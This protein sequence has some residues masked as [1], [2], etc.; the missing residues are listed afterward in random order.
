M[1]PVDVDQR[2]TGTDG[3][4]LLALPEGVL[5][6][7]LRA[8]WW[9]T[10]QPRLGLHRSAGVRRCD[11]LLVSGSLRLGP[12]RGHGEPVSPCLYVSG[13]CICRDHLVDL[14]VEVDV[15]LTRSAGTLRN[16]AGAVRRHIRTRAAGDWTRSRRLA[17]GAQARSDRIR[18]GAR[19]RQLP[20]DVHRAILEYLVDEAGSVAPL[21]D[22]DQLLTRLAVRAAAEFGGTAA[23]HRDR[24]LAMLPLIEAVC[25]TGPTSDS[26]DGEQ[27]TWWERYIDR[28]LGRRARRDVEIDAL[29]GEAWQLA[30]TAAEAAFYDDGTDDAQAT[31]SPVIAEL[32]R[33]RSPDL[34]LGVR[35]AVLEMAGLGLLPEPVAR[36]FV[37]DQR[38][39]GIAVDLLRAERRRAGGAQRGHLGATGAAGIQVHA[40]TD[41]L[42]A[43]VVNRCSVRGAPLLPIPRCAAADCLSGTSDVDRPRLR[44]LLGYGSSR[45]GDGPDAEGAP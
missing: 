42:R 11:L 22:G 27:L 5:D 29:P 16:P 21:D 6:A 23:G 13:E 40:D 24:V 41:I 18:G 8:V 43:C 44:A 17:M 33:V 30:C 34:A 10:H 38:R 19:A 25:R 9:E 15:F 1:Q 14:L 45:G 39:V 2:S 4:G 3:R 37:A 35:T 32:R 20:D 26:G 7:V 12:G 31:M 36:D 28:P